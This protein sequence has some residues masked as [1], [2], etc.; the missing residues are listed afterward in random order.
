MNSKGGETL[1]VLEPGVM[2]KLGIVGNLF[3]CF[4]LGEGEVLVLA[5]GESFASRWISWAF[6]DD[7]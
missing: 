3:Q 2:G 7:G 1:K 5:D 4:Q 6:P